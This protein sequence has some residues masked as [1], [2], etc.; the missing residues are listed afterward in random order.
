MISNSNI[1]FLFVY[2]VKQA[3]KKILFYYIVW[4]NNKKLMFWEGKCDVMKVGS[5]DLKSANGLFLKSKIIMP[6]GL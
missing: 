5:V 6:Y 3:V 2:S 1:V 4:N